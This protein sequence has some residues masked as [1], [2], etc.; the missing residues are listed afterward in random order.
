VVS[1]GARVSTAAELHV[2]IEMLTFR[3]AVRPDDRDVVRRIVASTGFFSEAEIDV[4]VE[5]VDERLARGDASGYYFVFAEQDGATIGYA[6]YGPIACTVGSFDLY[7]I[8]V[9][10]AHRGHG[11][12]RVI[13]E[14]TERR[15]AAP[16]W[17]GRRIYIETSGREQYAPTQ[18]F[19]TRCGYTLEARLKD[20]YSPGDD[21]LVYVRAIDRCN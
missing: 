8:A 3:E 7:W 18:G 6:C 9:D 17:R 15:I 5:L 19:Y 11:L 16:P 12:G 20:F 2:V 4:A 21:K 14:E 1:G 13:L 10:A